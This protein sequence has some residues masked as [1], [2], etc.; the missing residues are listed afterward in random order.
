[1]FKITETTQN[2][3]IYDYDDL[4]FD[5]EVLPN[6][7]CVSFLQAK[8]K[9][10]INRYTFQSYPNDSQ[11]TY[12]ELIKLISFIKTK[13]KD[14]IFIAWNVNYD[15][16]ILFEM[17]NIYK[18]IVRNNITV[19]NFD[20][21]I[22]NHQ[23]FVKSQDIINNNVHSYLTWDF[24]IIFYDAMKYLVNAKSL[25][26]SAGEAG[27]NILESNVSFLKSTLS[28]EDINQLIF[29]NQNDVDVLFRM[30]LKYY[31]AYEIKKDLTNEFS[32]NNLSAIE[33]KNNYFF[34]RIY[35]LTKNDKIPFFNEYY[36][37]YSVDKDNTIIPKKQEFN[38]ITEINSRP[39]L[40]KIKKIIDIIYNYDK[41]DDKIKYIL[42]KLKVDN[43]PI[44]A[45]KTYQLIFDK[46][47]LG[48]IF[49]MDVVFGLGGIHGSNYINCNRKAYNKDVA[50]YY[51]N[52]FINYNLQP[53]IIKN[54]KLDILP[55]L[56]TER[57][58]FKHSN[59]LNLKKK[60]KAYKIII[61]GNY[62][63]SRA[64][65]S[66]IYD[67][68]NGVILCIMGQ[69]FLLYLCNLINEHVM[70]FIQINTDGIYY[71]PKQGQNEIIDDI[72]KQWMELTHFDL[73]TDITTKTFNFD[74]N[75]YVILKDNGKIKAKGAYLNQYYNNI[76]DKSANEITYK[77]NIVSLLII[78]LL[79]Y[80]KSFNETISQ[81][82]ELWRYA[83][84]IR[85][86]SNYDFIYIDNDVN[87]I[88]FE[89][90]CKKY[91]LKIND[92][93]YNEIKD[94]VIS[95]DYD[96]EANKINQK[97][98][99]IFATKTGNHYKK[100][101]YKKQRVLDNN[102]VIDGHLMFSFNKNIFDIKSLKKGYSITKKRYEGENIPD[103]PQTAYVYNQA[104]FNNYQNNYNL[105]Q[106]DVKTI[107]DF[108]NET[109][110]EIDLDYY[111]EFARKR[112]FE[113]YGLDK[114]LLSSMIVN[115]DNLIS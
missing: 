75:N 62:G 69:I 85:T 22:F 4:C 8:N 73:E 96:F 114:E 103:I 71:I 58:T 77:N 59:D 80:N 84:V 113:V 66:N 2:K 81:N 112:L 108:Y 43:L 33:F 78:N 50:S 11:K 74:V 53:R 93:I 54:N 36:G 87:K 41:L 39:E 48:Q 92:L 100:Y 76:L 86:G 35:N 51:P 27:F 104:L 60:D 29:Y 95:D 13:A 115:L 21:T 49:N 20:Q 109:N 44:S 63:L 28:Q 24:N 6:F 3:T 99:R 30:L 57:L 55:K 105:S 12:Q 56:K 15:K 42:D 83:N 79:I 14:N 72:C 46:N 52:G 91:N 70:S 61:N 82:Q 45:N 19:D 98:I 9:Q 65:I 110:I 23:L 106:N 102:P 101:A 40:N 5:F 26:A 47:H 88:T 97:V 38:F 37:G 111:K 17:V 32:N 31:D 94:K 16:T 90:Y 7:W 64:V 67:P 107:T 68:I 10:P 25:K 89:N 18:N 1:M 34:N